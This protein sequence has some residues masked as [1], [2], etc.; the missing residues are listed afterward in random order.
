MTARSLPAMRS[1]GE[2]AIALLLDLLAGAGALLVAGRTWQTVLTPRPRPLADDVLPL[3]GHV[4]DSAA[5]AL[6]LVA[7]SGVVAVLATRG[8]ARRAVGVV[9]ALTGALL[10]WRSLTG[11]GPVSAARARTLVQ[12]RHSGVGVDATVVPQLSVHAQ[13]PLLSAGCGVLV[14]AGGLLVALRGPGW[15]SMSVR[16]DA[17]SARQ[18]SAQDRAATRARADASMWTALDRGDD[19][20]SERGSGSG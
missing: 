13:W 15:A 6:G 12:A 7:L 17:P 20:T 5:T 9:L 8:G 3:T 18:L 19:P 2:F 4:L 14:V 10:V 16:Y 11:L 1:R